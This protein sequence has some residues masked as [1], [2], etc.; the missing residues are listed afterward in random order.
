M[1]VIRRYSAW[2]SIRSARLRQNEFCYVENISKAKFYE[3][4]K[5]GLGPDVTNIDG[6]HTDHTGSAR[7]VA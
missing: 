7:S 5:R 3:L 1:A 2:T 6:L 4:K